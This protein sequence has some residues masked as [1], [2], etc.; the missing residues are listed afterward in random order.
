M[1]MVIVMAV[2]VVIGAAIAVTGKESPTAKAQ[3]TDAGIGRRV[4]VAA[5]AI[6]ATVVGA[7]I[8][9]NSAAHRRDPGIT[10][11]ILIVVHTGAKGGGT[12]D[13]P[14]Q[15]KEFCFHN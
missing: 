6:P 15:R 3:E 7:I 12:Q 5:V 13:H 1:V 10:V 4:A 14:S 8:H 2:A 9:V 11:T